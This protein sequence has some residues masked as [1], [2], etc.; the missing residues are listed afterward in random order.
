MFSIWIQALAVQV[1]SLEEQLN[2]AIASRNT[3]TVPPA[4]VVATPSAAEPKE[5][6]VDT[7][8]PLEEPPSTEVKR[9]ATFPSI[10]GSIMIQ[11]H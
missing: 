2:V 4:E 8:Q 1:A 7:P 10:V 3:A 11:E 5:A 6:P 9:A